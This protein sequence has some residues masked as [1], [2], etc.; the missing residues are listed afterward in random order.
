M[1]AEF[2]G[3]FL[4]LLLHEKNIFPTGT[5][6]NF[7]LISFPVIKFICLLADSVQRFPT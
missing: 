6:V 3:A 2:R 4:L 7:L 1:A 5:K